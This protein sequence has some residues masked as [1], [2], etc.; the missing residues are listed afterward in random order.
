MKLPHAFALA[1]L[2][3][4]WTHGRQYPAIVSQNKCQPLAPGHNNPCEMPC[5]P[6]F[7]P[8]CGNCPAGCVAINA[9]GCCQ[10]KPTPSQFNIL[11]YGAVPDGKTLATRSI[12]EAIH[13][14]ARE[15]VQRGRQAQVVVP[16]GVFLTGA[17]SL[18]SGV[19]LKLDT[20]SILRV[21]HILNRVIASVSRQVMRR[22]RACMG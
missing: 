15:W 3:T 8:H 7:G 11:D 20:G 12:L 18:S 9:C 1:L 5:P 13:A 14:A 6:C 21:R 22:K 10:P 4:A 2:L 17:F 16:A 19:V